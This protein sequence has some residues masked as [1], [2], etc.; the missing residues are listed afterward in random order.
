MQVFLFFY[1]SYSFTRFLKGEPVKF[2]VF[3]PKSTFYKFLKALFLMFLLHLLLLPVI[4]ILTLIIFF[5]FQTSLQSTHFAGREIE[6]QKG[7]K[8]FTQDDSAWKNRFWTFLSFFIP[9]KKK[10]MKQRFPDSS[11]RATSLPWLLEGPHVWLRF[12]LEGQRLWLWVL[13]QNCRDGAL[14]M[15]TAGEGA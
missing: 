9:A 6:A 4:L 15:V 14:T 11:E 7:T 1:S 12:L 13:L 3:P 5:C 10:R 2:L 8:W